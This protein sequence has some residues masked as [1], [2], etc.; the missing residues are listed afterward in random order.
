MRRWLFVL[1]FAALLV[2]VATPVRAADDPNDAAQAALA[3]LLARQADDGS[4]PGFDAGSTADVVFA[5]VAAGV[6]PNGVLKNGNSPISYLGTQA[7]AFAAKS[8]AAAGKLMLAVVAAEKDPFDFNQQNLVALIMQ[9]YDPTAGRYGATT[10]DHVYALLALASAG[11]PIPQGALDALGSAQLPDGGWSFDGN[12]ATGSD[13]NTT[14]L[15]AQALIAGGVRGE[16][17]TKALGYLKSQQNADGGFPYSKTSSFGSDSDAN[18]TA[19]V[20]Q[21]LV[22]AGE[23][24]AGYAPEGNDPFDALLSFQNESNAFRYQAAVPD[25]N[26]LATAQAIPALLRK[27][28]P[29]KTATL[30]A[31]AQAAPAPPNLLPRTGGSFDPAWL[32]GL[33]LLLVAAGFALRPTRR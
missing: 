13:T 9:S 30:S 2:G 16:P 31:P 1:A 18:S 24:L 25:D 8:P 15:A 27:P 28:F 7:Q 20:I 3:W 29:L 19:L 26:D 5:M 32:A 11:Q 6:D 23:D 14:A 17:L 33:A 22:A 21:A 10:T 4:F 12:P